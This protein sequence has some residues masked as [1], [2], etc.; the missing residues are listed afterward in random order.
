MNIV[1]P[2][3]TVKLSNK[4]DPKWFDQEFKKATA[5]RKKLRES[6]EKAGIFTTDI[7][8]SVIYVENCH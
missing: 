1:A 5:L 2:E 6:R 7:L 8:N 4:N 3:A